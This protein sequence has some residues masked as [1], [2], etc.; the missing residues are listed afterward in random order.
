MAGQVYRK[1]PEITPSSVIINPNQQYNTPE[2]QSPPNTAD[3]G[4][5]GAH[6]LLTEIRQY[7]AERQQH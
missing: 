3:Q 6:T 2:N 4:G 7:T 1:N 5:K